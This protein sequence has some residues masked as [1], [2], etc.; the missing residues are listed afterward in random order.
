MPVYR[1]GK[2]KAR[3]FDPAVTEHMDYTPEELE[4]FRAMDR[5]RQSTGYQFPTLAETLQVLRSLGYEKNAGGSV[6]GP[7]FRQS[8]KALSDGGNHKG[9]ND[10]THKGSRRRI[11][12]TSH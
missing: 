6:A 5:Y 9:V 4:F 8:I 3:R 10:G 7:H 1:N 12:R 2:N 11:N